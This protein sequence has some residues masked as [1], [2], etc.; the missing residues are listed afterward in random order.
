M[1]N[2]DVFDHL[3]PFWAHLDLLGPFQTKN[4]F[5]QKHLCQN[6][7]CP[8]VA[9]H[10]FLSE[11]VQK[12]LDGP[13]KGPKSS[14]TSRFTISDTFGPPWTT[15]ECWQARQFGHFCLFHLCVFWDTLYYL[16]F[17]Y[18]MCNKM[19]L[20]RKERATAW[21]NKNFT[22]FQNFCAELPTK[23]NPLSVIQLAFGWIN[24]SSKIYLKS[25]PLKFEPFKRHSWQSRQR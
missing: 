24:H 25:S 21:L 4:D 16:P 19:P 12:C 10:W 13:K 5:A 17:Q 3:G 14:K 11:M 8:Y 9:T 1:I 2:L 22:V 7:L 18:P 6:L 15:L 20:S 23:Y